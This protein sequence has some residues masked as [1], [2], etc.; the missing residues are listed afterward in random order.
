MCVAIRSR[1]KRS[2]RDDHCAASEILKRFFERP[3]RVDIEIVGRLVE[4]KNIRA[5]F[6]HFGQMTRLRSPP[7]SRPTFF[8]WSEPLKLNAEHRRAS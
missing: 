6:Q 3:Q 7:E 8:C 5:G 2:W 1:K 4:K